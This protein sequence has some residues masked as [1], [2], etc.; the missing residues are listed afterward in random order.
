MTDIEIVHGHPVIPADTPG[1]PSPDGIRYDATA[2]DPALQE[3]LIAK[4][5]ENAT[6]NGVPPVATTTDR[7]ICL[8]VHM[9]YSCPEDVDYVAAEVE[10]RDDDGVGWNH[11]FTVV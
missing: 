3:L 6:V 4:V 1:L 2:F 9:D 7:L 10:A 8:T 11:T 5:V